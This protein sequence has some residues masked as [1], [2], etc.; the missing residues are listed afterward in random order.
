MP[1]RAIIHSYGAPQDV[2]KF[3]EIPSRSLLPQ[4][5]R[6][7]MHLTPINPADLNLIEGPYGIR[8]SLPTVPGHEGFGEVKEI[9]KEVHHLKV[10]DWVRP[11]TQGTWQQEIL[12]PENEF[13][14]LP[15]KNL[16][17]EFVSQIWVNPSA[18]WRMLHDFVDLK[19]GDWIIQNAST[20]AVGHSVIQIAK[21]YGWKTLSLVRRPEEIEKLKSLGGDEVFV[22]NDNL[23]DE[24]KT[25]AKNHIPRL[26]LNAVGGESATNI[27][28]TLSPNGILVTYGAMSKQPLSIPNGLLIFKNIQVR[29]FW[30]TT[31]QKN[32]STSEIS[33]TLESLAQLHRNGKLELPIEK[34]YSFSELQQAILHSSKTP[35]TGKVLVNWQS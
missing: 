6:V 21:A 27:I 17:P 5:V 19:P 1:T 24:L 3:E 9:G 11:L 25:W 8:P 31:W 16:T 28:K 35:K 30:V 23:R 29:G 20:S 7:E 26:G 15:Q 2:L 22:E 13:L 10:G 14:C 33:T 18:A 12:S 32:A 34:I 4:E